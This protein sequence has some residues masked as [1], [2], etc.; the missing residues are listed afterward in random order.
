MV[1]HATKLIFSRFIVYQPPTA[2]IDIE[3]GQY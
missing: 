2:L 3:L 1:L